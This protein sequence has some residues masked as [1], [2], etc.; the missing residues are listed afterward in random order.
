[1]PSASNPSP[2]SSHIAFAL[3]LCSHLDAK[4]TG[5]CHPQL[6]GHMR[7]KQR[8]MDL[9]NNQQSYPKIFPFLLLAA[10]TA[11]WGQEWYLFHHWEPDTQ[12]HCGHSCNQALRKGLQSKEWPIS[13]QKCLRW[14]KW[15]W[16]TSK[17]LQWISAGRRDGMVVKVTDWSQ[18]WL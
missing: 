14:H 2:R 11:S 4:Y 5:K 15:I 18:C 12:W 6:G 17:A 1:M 3:T 16:W 13:F 10:D 7:R 9:Q 8:K